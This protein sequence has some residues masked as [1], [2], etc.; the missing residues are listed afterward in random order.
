MIKKL[1]DKVVCLKL[2]FVVVLPFLSDPK[3][4]KDDERPGCPEGKNLA[5]LVGTSSEMNVVDGNFA[6]RILVEEFKTNSQT[7]RQILS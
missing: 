4:S 5:K 1:R 6:V 7:V 3:D 2:E